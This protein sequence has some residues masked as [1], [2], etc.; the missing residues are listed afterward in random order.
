MTS[1]CHNCGREYLTARAMAGKSVACRSCGALNDG[2]G[3]PPPAQSPRAGAQGSQSKPISGE[4]FSVGEKPRKL[5]PRA[6]ERDYRAAVEAKAAAEV[7]TRRESDGGSARLVRTLGIAALALT[8]VIVGG[9]FLFRYLNQ[10]PVDTNWARYQLAV[11]QITSALATGTGFVIE[12]KRQLWLVTN[13]HVIEGAREVTA[14][15]RS[16]A[17]GSVLFRAAGLPTSE[18]RVHPRFLVAKEGAEDGRSFDLAAISIEDYRPNLEKIGLEP[19]EIASLGE[20]AVGARV[21]A[22]GHVGARG[23]NLAAEGDDAAVGVATHSLFDGVVSNVRRTEG[24]PTLV[25]TSANFSNGCSGGPLMLEQSMKVAGVNTW[26]ALNSDGTEKAA[27]K[28]ALAA[29]Q[30]FDI[31]RTGTPLQSLR[32]EIQRAATDPLPP[33]GVVEEARN[34]STFPGIQNI[35]TFLEEN[36]WRMTGRGIAVTDRSGRGAHRHRVIGAGGA[37]VAVLA[38]PRD[39]SIDLNL[40]EITGEQFRGLGQDLNPQHG[41]AA[42]IQVTM[43][44]TNVP[45]VISQGFEI[46]IAVETLFLGDPIA[47]RYL[48]IVF[49]RPALAAGALE[50]PLPKEQEPMPEPKPEANSDP[51]RAPLPRLAP[52]SGSRPAVPPSNF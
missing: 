24:K 17:D 21:V 41:T 39:R 32:R 14:L 26:G 34:W 42:M 7:A 6:V 46:S 9:T 27:M 19:L 30:A 13:F 47:A 8:L 50:E 29:D 3:G 12:D 49:E 36:G 22:L 44:G 25:Q 20:I 33:A 45:A 18:F 28:F 40:V 38:L 35:L 16:P 4:A 31:I 52:P 37:E 10:K 1:H 2:A 51:L 43:P 48:I 15:F 23:F 11:P 5:D